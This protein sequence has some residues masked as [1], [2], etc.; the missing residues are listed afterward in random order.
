MLAVGDLEFQRKC[1]GKM[2]EVSREGRTVSCRHQMD[3]L[4]RLCQRC[5]WLD[6]GRIR[7]MGAVAEAIQ[8]YEHDV[9]SGEGTGDRTHF[10]R[11]ELGDGGHTFAH[12][13]RPVTIR[14]YLRLTEP[15][16]GGHYGVG[17]RNSRDVLVAGWAFE[18]VSLAEGRHV[19][20]VHLPQLPLQPGAYQVSFELFNGGNRLAG[21]VAVDRWTGVPL[22]NLDVPPL[23]HGQDALAGILN[24]RAS[25]ESRDADAPDL[26]LEPTTCVGNASPV[27]A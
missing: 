5:V 27:R 21:G 18:P 19:L 13:D 3:Q 2:D 20:D 15:V 17:L 11:W 22:L 14:A 10:M 9:T 6:G 23:G 25:L 7:Y 26:I 16:V 12:S 1:L 8:R 4:R 24:V